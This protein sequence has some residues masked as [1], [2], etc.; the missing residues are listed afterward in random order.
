MYS[1]LQILAGPTASAGRRRT[2]AAAP[3]P[4]SFSN[5]RRDGCI[6]AASLSPEVLAEPGHAAIPGEL[7]CLGIV[8]LLA[9]RVQERVLRVVA[10]D[11]AGLARRL[12]L[13][14]E[15]VRLFLR[16]PPVL[17][18]EVALDGSAHVLARGDV[19]RRQ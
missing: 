5:E 7:R 13:L 1:A 10:V 12:Q 11:L 14:L 6:T 8:D 4:A 2:D 15:L 19:G 18:G 16:H 9:V 17:V 3:A